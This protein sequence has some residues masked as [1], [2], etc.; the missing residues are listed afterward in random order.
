MFLSLKGATCSQCISGWAPDTPKTF[1]PNCKGCLEKK[2]IGLRTGD[3]PHPKE[4]CRIMRERQRANKE[5]S[6]AVRL[7]RKKMRQS[8]AMGKCR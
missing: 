8:Q 5:K 7:G 1:D 4:F 6:Q 3:E 2:A